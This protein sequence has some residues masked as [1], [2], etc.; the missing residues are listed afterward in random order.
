MHSPSISSL[1]N[2][3]HSF[4]AVNNSSENKAAA[5]GQRPNLPDLTF[6]SNVSN[7]DGF[8]LFNNILQ[9][10]YQRIS[11]GPSQVTINQVSAHKYQPV[12]KI[13]ANQAAGT[14][15]N[16]ISQQLQSDETNG[17]SKEALL[18]RLDAGLEG[19]NKALQEN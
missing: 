5:S 2:T 1:L 16:S 17:A 3:G 19:F 9:K 14:I 4:A 10:A 13:S 8:E 12:D 6:R 7:R 15:L 11:N 18:S